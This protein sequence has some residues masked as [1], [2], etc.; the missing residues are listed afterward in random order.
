MKYVV[1]MNVVSRETGRPTPL[2]VS[3]EFKDLPRAAA[4]RAMVQY[5]AQHGVHV[6]ATPSSVKS[7]GAPRRPPKAQLPSL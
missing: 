3:C 5:C 4:V 6:N 1:T 2:K 7:V